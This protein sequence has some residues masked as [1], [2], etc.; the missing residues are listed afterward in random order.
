MRDRLR[1]TPQSRPLIQR[2]ETAVKEV[3]IGEPDLALPGSFGTEVCIGS[4]YTLSSMASKRAARRVRCLG[5]GTQTH[6]SQASAAA[7]SRRVLTSR[8][9]SS[10]KDPPLV[11]ARFCRCFPPQSVL[12]A[13]RPLYLYSLSLPHAYRR[14]TER[15]A[16]GPAPRLAPPLLTI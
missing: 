1:E 8:S 11:G 15:P 3:E 13:A 4:S 14:A 10:P 2:G 16:C 12:A 6:S 5:I 9:P 7:L